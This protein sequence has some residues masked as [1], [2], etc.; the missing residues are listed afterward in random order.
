LAA[1]FLIALRLR[2]LAPL[3]LDGMLNPTPERAL[4]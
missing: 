3:Q 4:P 2:G 1:S